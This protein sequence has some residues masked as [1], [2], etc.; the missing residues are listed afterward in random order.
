MVADCCSLADGIVTPSRDDVEQPRRRR[1]FRIRAILIVALA[2]TFILCFAWRQLLV[3][4]AFLFR[5]ND[6]VPSDVLVVLTGGEYDRAVQAAELY[7]RG[8]GPIIL[9]CSDSDTKTN[10]RDMVNAGVPA[11]AIRTLGAVSNTHG[12]AVQVRDYLEASPVRR[13]TVVTTAY[14]SARARWV[15]RRVLRPSGVEVHAAATEDAR[16]TESTWYQSTAGRRAYL[17]E[18]FKTIYYRLA[19]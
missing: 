7:R 14:H 5:A 10:I 8:F 2:V 12:E 13:I 6:P 16:F 17:R 1:R 3:G 11:E 15:F 19:Y 4:Y 9:I 18:L